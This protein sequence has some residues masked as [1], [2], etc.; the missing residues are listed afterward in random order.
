MPDSTHQSSSKL[1]SADSLGLSNCS[2]NPERSK[3]LSEKEASREALENRIFGLLCETLDS[4]PLDSG[5]AQR[6]RER[7]ER[8]GVA[9]TK[10]AI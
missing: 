2:D 3:A 1:V 7:L 10:E 5:I 9:P 6:L 8:E 4:E